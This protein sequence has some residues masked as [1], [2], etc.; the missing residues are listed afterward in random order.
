MSQ[1]LFQ[2]GSARRD[3]EGLC[4][5][6]LN[7]PSESGSQQDR[8]TFYSG[9][10]GCSSVPSGAGAQAGGDKEAQSHRKGQLCRS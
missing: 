2:A 10:L 3:E 9:L 6:V 8:C 5:G 1:R 7:R 4:M